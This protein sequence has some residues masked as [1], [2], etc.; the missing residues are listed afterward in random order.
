M[1]EYKFNIL[2]ALKKAGYN[3][4]TLRKDNLLSETIINK[5]RNNDTSISLVT[6]DKICE[7]LDM[8]PEQLIKRSLQKPLG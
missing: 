4:Y 5:L 8:Q 6:L 3:T 2:D 7:L 1:I